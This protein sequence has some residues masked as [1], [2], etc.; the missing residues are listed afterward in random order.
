[1]TGVCGGGGGGGQAHLRM[2]AWEQALGHGP[3]VC[4]QQLQPLVLKAHL[5]HVDVHGGHVL[6]ASSQP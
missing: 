2:I 6:V 1:M 4:P 3:H 5:L